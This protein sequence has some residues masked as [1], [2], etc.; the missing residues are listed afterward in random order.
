M[1]GQ[2]G[3]VAL[4]A[5]RVLSKNATTAVVVAALLVALFLIYETGGLI[6]R[7]LSDDAAEAVQAAVAT[8]L[9]IVA[10]ALL[11]DL[12]GGAGSQV[13][14]ALQSSRVLD[15]GTGVLV[16]I[17]LLVLAIA[18]TATRFTKRLIHLSE[19]RNHISRHQQEV[20]HHVVQLLIYLPALLFIL[21][22]A[23]ADPQ[24]LILSAGAATV[25]LGFAARETLGAVLSGFVLLFSRPF[26]VGDWVVVDDREGVIVD[27]SVVN[28]RIRTF[29]NEVLVI[30]ND[31]VTTEHILN[32]SRNGQLRIRTEVGIDYG[33]DPAEAAT[34]AEEAM[35]GIDV[36]SD[37]RESDVVTKRFANS[38]VL[39]ELRFWIDEPTIQRKWRAQ[40]EVMD[41]V[42]GAFA[43]HGIKI[44]YPQRELTGREETGGLRVA[45][46]ED[47]DG[48][49][50]ADG[51]G[52]GGTEPDDA[53]ETSGAESA[54]PDADEGSERTPPASGEGAEPPADGEG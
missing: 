5:H 32:R 54:D 24:D 28:T 45:G 10:A 49:H 22:L 46:A 19:G 44:P 33:D 7:Y 41:A 48:D 26:E 21:A 17:A 20:L 52:E 1:T 31:E 27:I 53:E 39:L 35:T 4:F 11:L 50:V 30:P 29:D 8:S 12:H 2:P 47:A 43:E 23:G 42:K 3:L 14:T 38:S 13:A 16:M 15:P 51:T 37:D 25:V 34:V 6:R 9:G 40:N 36:L 18:Y